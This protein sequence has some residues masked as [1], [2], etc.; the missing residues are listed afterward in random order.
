MREFRVQF[1]SGEGDLFEFSEEFA[2]R[3]ELERKYLHR[4]KMLDDG[5]VA[6]L[7]ECHGPA[8]IVEEVLDSAEQVIEVMATGRETTFYYVHFEP[9]EQSRQMM[10]MCRGTS[11]TLNMPLELHTDGS[12]VGTYVGQQSELGD[13]LEQLPES[14]QAELLRV[15]RDVR[16]G[17]DPSAALTERQREILTVAIDQGYYAHP[18]TATQSDIAAELDVSAATV[19]EH[20]RKIEAQILG[21]CKQ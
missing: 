13:A 6:S 7:G 12:V 11:V 1:W 4:M 21:S 5:T 19:G 14:V 2:T 16:A 20:L 9:C 3:P 18:R 8:E 17:E 10:M 15:R